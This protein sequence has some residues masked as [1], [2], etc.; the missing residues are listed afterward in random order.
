[1][2][3]LFTTI[4]SFICV[5]QLCA[6]ET[7]PKIKYFDL[8]DI[9]LLD[10][11][12]KRAQDLD[13]KYLLDLDADRLLAPFLREAGLQKK[14]ES[15]TNW[16]NTGLDGHIGGHYVSALALM[17]ASTGDEQIKNRLD[18]MISE[19]KRC[20]DE[21]GNGYIGG[22]PGGKAIW[23]EIAKGDIQASGF[24]L[25]NRWVPLYN[26]HK[27]YAGLRDAYLIAGNE[28]A[29]DMLIKM[30]DWAIKLVSN[31]SEEQI[32]DMLRSEHGGLNETF[33]DVAVITQNEK[34]L[35]LAHQFS[36]Q[37][38]LNPLLA[39]EDKLTGLHANTQIPKVLGFKRIADIEGKMCIRDSHKW[40]KVNS[41]MRLKTV[42][43]HYLSKGS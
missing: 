43:S 40:V 2:K 39:H 27:T 17:Y 10:S 22:V 41:M 24:G 31:L 33:A 42:F 8:K 29:K 16:E 4:F 36:H 28:T 15:Y 13:K 5:I 9:T 3:K 37:L 6:Q 12:F 34:Y 35:K 23:D 18:Y 20:Q 1:M 26:I 25:N 19:L 21:N 14:A 7:T 38:I 11:P 32:Q 30:T